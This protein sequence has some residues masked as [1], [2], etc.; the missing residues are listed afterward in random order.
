MDLSYRECF[1]ILGAPYG[2]GVTTMTKCYRKL[3]S[4]WHPD[5]HPGNESIALITTQRINNAREVLDDAYERGVVFQREADN[6]QHRERYETKHT[7]SR[8]WKNSIYT[9]GFPDPNA[10][11]I[12]VKSSNIL[13]FGYN[14]TIEVLYVKYLSNVVYAYYDVPLRI[15]EGFLVAES[16][17]RYRN[18]HVDHFRYERLEEVN[19]PYCGNSLTNEGRKF[20]E[21]RKRYLLG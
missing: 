11:E 7:A 9:P 10:L 8:R 14:A 5:R 21:R 3:I 1:E 19:V 18:T 13:S 16:A 2:C 6:S 15:Y 17:G 12:F 20:Q 4:R